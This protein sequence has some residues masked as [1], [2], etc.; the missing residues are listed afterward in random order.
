MYLTPKEAA[1]VSGYSLSTL[2]KLRYAGKIKWTAAKSGRKV[3]YHKNDLLK[4]AGI[5]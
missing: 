1:E 5:I 4:Y 3:R 2:N